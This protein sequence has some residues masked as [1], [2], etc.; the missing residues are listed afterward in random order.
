M[1]RAIARHRPFEI[2]GLENRIFNQSEVVK[3]YPASSEVMAAQARA[4]LTIRNDGSTTLDA[5]WLP[6]GNVGRTKS[7]LRSPRI[8]SSKATQDASNKEQS[9]RIQDHVSP[10]YVIYM[11]SALLGL[12][13]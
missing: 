7:N 9:F 8:R 12:D 3:T 5:P 1:L 13:N 4:T 10:P 11:A 6:L 2:V